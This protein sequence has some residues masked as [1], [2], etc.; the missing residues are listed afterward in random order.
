MIRKSGYRFCLGTNAVRVCPRSCTLKAMERHDDSKKSRPALAGEFHKM[1]RHHPV[2]VAPEWHH[3]IGDAVEPLPAPGIEFGRLAVAQRQR[4]DLVVAADEP[5]REPFLPLAAEL[6]EAMCGRSVIGRKFIFYPIGLAEIFGADRPGLLPEFAHD[7]I[8]RVLVGV[9]T[10]LWHLPFEAR[11]DDFGSVVPEAPANQHL[12]KWVEQ[13]DPDI[14]AI[15]LAVCH[16]PPDG[17]THHSNIFI[18]TII[19]YEH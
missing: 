11:Q 10:A 6:G 5:Q 17:G 15:G 3:E 14:G 7:G 9:D 4:V 1:P 19:L 8:A 13:R 18:H 16:L 2:H 12:A